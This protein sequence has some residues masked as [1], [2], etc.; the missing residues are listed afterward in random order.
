M[1]I[2][3]KSFGLLGSILSC[4]V[5]DG[6]LKVLQSH[7]ALLISRLVIRLHLFRFFTLFNGSWRD[8]LHI[9]LQ[10]RI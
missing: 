5:H 1:V 6:L 4:G 8:K 10:L 9:L 2:F 3:A 7:Q